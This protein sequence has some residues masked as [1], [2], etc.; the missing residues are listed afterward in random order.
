MAT[1]N[2]TVTAD[3]VETGVREVE[4]VEVQNNRT[5]ADHNATANGTV[6]TASQ[7]QNGPGATGNNQTGPGSLTETAQSAGVQT[8][9]P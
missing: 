7:K 4:S 1:A 9:K 5:G 3:P 8:Q 6:T 2:D